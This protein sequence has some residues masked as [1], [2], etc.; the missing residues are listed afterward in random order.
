MNIRVD[1]QYLMQYQDKLK[2]KPQPHYA[3][4]GGRFDEVFEKELGEI[5][6]GRKNKNNSAIRG[7]LY[8]HDMSQRLSNI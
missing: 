3:H 6:K 5:D 2:E 7:I 1:P 4:D 8:F